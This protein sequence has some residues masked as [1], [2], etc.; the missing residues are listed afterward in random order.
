MAGNEPGQSSAAYW[1][2]QAANGS[3][4]CFSLGEGPSV[5]KER[6]DNGKDVEDEAPLEPS[7]ELR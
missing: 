7:L 6:Q 4:E 5:L 2:S 1:A 3:L